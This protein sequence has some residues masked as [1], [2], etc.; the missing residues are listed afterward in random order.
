MVKMFLNLLPSSLIYFLLLC[1]YS[2]SVFK[3][4]QGLPWWSRI[5]LSMQKTHVPSPIQEDST[6][7]RAAKR[8]RQ[9]HRA[10]VSHPLMAAHPRAMLQNHKR[11]SSHSWGKRPRAAT[12]TRQSQ[13]A[14]PTACYLL[15]LLVILSSKKKKKEHNHNTIISRKTLIKKSWVYIIHSPYLNFPDWS[16]MLF[17]LDCS[18]QY[19]QKGM[20]LFC[21]LSLFN[22][23]ESLPFLFCMSWTVDKTEL[24]CMMSHIL[25]WTVSFILFLY[26]LC[27]LLGRNYF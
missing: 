9:E 23:E 17:K 1:P 20:Q 12:K 21:I 6:C 14:R 19:P 16:Q 27:F 5:C 13:K 25:E 24:S 3:Q 7:H 22:A 15:L 4:I 11:P 2:L 26:P 8:K 18:T 10:R